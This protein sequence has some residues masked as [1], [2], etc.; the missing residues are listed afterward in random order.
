MMIMMMAFVSGADESYWSA[1]SSTVAAFDAAADSY[2]FHCLLQLVACDIVLKK[3]LISKWI[4]EAYN[5]TAFSDRALMI[6]KM[7]QPCLVL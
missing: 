3:M 5:M 4:T 6:E 1:K 2:T 7:F